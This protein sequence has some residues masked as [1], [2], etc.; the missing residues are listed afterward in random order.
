MSHQYLYIIHTNAHPT[1]SLS[2]CV[3]VREIFEPVVLRR[4]TP[5]PCHRRQLRLEDPRLAME[6]SPSEHQLQV[7]HVPSVSSVT[8]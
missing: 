5:W 3:T 7:M 1:W 6:V 2:H 4:H 8:L